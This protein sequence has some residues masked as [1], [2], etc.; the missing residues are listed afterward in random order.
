MIIN[1]LIH[2]HLFNTYYVQVL[3]LMLPL[4]AGHKVEL[5]GTDCPAVN[6]HVLS[7]AIGEP[8]QRLA[9]VM[10]MGRQ[11]EGR[12]FQIKPKSY[13]LSLRRS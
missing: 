2:K 7:P 12:E 3:H 4:R 10:M 9:A 6:M 1:S 13:C 5:A 8:L 11:K